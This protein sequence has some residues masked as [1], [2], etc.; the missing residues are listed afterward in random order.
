MARVLV[1]AAGKSP[2]KLACVR[3]FRV[4]IDMT[5]SSQTDWVLLNG[6]W[7]QLFLSATMLGCD[8]VPRCHVLGRVFHVVGPVHM[9][10]PKLQ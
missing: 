1:G 7:L 6:V 3:V 9:R 8:G 2:V 5:C 4:T 10:L